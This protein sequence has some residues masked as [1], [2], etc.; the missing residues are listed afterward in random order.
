M[1][2]GPRARLWRPAAH[3]CLL[4][5]G[6]PPGHFRSGEPPAQARGRGPFTL[7]LPGQKMLHGP[8][9]A[10]LFLFQAKRQQALQHLM[11]LHAQET[12]LTLNPYLSTTA[13]GLVTAT[14]IV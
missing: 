11:A 14:E 4:S 5:H 10:F 8:S 12:A 3:R 6:F 2:L 7:S 9:L 1:G 13:V